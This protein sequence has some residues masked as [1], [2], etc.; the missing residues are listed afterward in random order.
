MEPPAKPTAAAPKMHP[1]GGAHSRPRATNLAIISVQTKMGGCAGGASMEEF[2]DALTGGAIW[3]IGFGVALG[4]ART[5]GGGLR[6]MV[7]EA[8]KGAIAVGDWVG[9]TVAEGRET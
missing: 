8:M 9:G 3:G 7:K 5:A 6:P 2:V 4:L 1:P